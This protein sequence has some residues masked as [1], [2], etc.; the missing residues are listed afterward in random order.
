MAAVPN[1]PMPTPKSLLLD[2]LEKRLFNLLEDADSRF[3]LIIWQA[4][5]NMPI[6]A[7]RV[8]IADKTA[9]KLIYK[10]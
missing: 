2:A 4:M 10:S 8:R 6:P 1:A 3:V 7:V 5:R 9:A